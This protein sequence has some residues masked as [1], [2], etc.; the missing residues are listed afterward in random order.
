M[1]T[2]L[3]DLQKN[4]SVKGYVLNYVRIPSPLG[5]ELDELV[6][7]T[8]YLDFD[9][10]TKKT[11]AVTQCAIVAD[12]ISAITEKPFVFDNPS[13]QRDALFNGD[14]ME[15]SPSFVMANIDTNELPSIKQVKAYY[16][17]LNFIA[18]L[19]SGAEF[20]HSQKPKT[21]PL[22]TIENMNTPF[23]EWGKGLIGVYIATIMTCEK[24]NELLNKDKGLDNAMYDDLRARILSESD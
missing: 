11:V 23:V 17:K 15:Y 20:L 10:D 14:E 22:L 9:R 6:D 4:L 5:D 13:I 1:Q 7:Y 21:V 8:N 3:D 24:A 12:I 2:Y 18:I 19:L 16:S